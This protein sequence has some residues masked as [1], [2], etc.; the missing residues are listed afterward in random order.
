MENRQADAGCAGV[1]PRE[2]MSTHT[3][4]RQE[5]AVGLREKVL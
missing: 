5:Q 4:A 1:W 3:Q 2:G